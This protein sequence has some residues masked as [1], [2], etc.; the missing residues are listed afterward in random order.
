MPAYA[1][2]GDAMETIVVTGTRITASGFQAPTP[3]SMISAV[4][5]E[6]NAQPNIFTTITQLPSLMGSAGVQNNTYS[7]S[8]G[9]Q[10]L[11]SFSLRGLGTIRTLTLLDGQRVVGANVTGTPDVSL[12]PQILIERVDVVTGGASASWGS[13]AVG[14]V[15]NFVTN[16]HF[17]GVKAN[18]QGGISTY[19]DNAQHMIQLAVGKSFLGGRLHVAVAGE[20]DHEDGVPAGDLG[21]QAANGRTWYHAATFLNTGMNTKQS[22]Y[23]G[24]PQYIVSGHAQS[25]K[26][27]KY[28]LIN[29]GPLAG[30]AFDASGK[31]YPFVY[32]TGLGVAT[33]PSYQRGCFNGFCVGGD[34]S[35]GIGMGASITSSLHRL[36]AYTRVG[37]D[38]NSD[39]EIY[40]TVNMS[41]VNTSNQPYVGTS[42]SGLTI[43]CSNP[44]VPASVQQAC[45]ANNIT[46]FSFGTV[47]G[48]F[49]RDPIVMP[50]RK[51]VRLVVGADG[52]FD[53]AGVNWTYDAYLEHGTNVTDIHVHNI[54]LN[55]RY[56][57]AVNAT[58]LN[59]QA[60][61]ANATARAAGCVPLNVFG[62]D[63]VPDAVMDYI[64]PANGP[65]QHT[66]QTQDVAS[67]AING[68]PLSLWAGPVAVAFGGEYRREYYRV[69]A[70]PYGNGLTSTNTF[71]DQ[72]PA[73][74]V[75]NFDPAK[76][77]GS[78]WFAGN[79]HD[80]H[81]AF[82]VKEVF[83][84]TNV[85]V[86]DSKVFGSGNINLA[87]RWEDYSTAGVA[88]TWKIG[89]T[90][91]TPIEGVRFRGVISSDVRA[92]NLSELFAAPISS[93][94][95]N[96]TNPFNNSTLTV[97][98]NTVGNP[99]L[100]PEVAHNTEVGVVLS[101]PSWLPGFNASVDY[102]RI[103][104]TGVIN[105]TSDPVT[106]CYQGITS[107]C[108]DSSDYTVPGK[109]FWLPTAPGTVG[110]TNIQAFNMAW[111][112]TEGLDLEASY[113]FHLEDY[114]PGNF[115]VR[116]LATNVF[117][118]L[119]N[120]GTKGAVD[121][122]SAGNNSGSTP[123][124]KFLTVQSYDNE[125]FSFNIQE[126]WF[127]D[128]VVNRSYIQC[129]TNCPIST[130]NYRTVSDNF[131]AGAFYLDIGG[132]YNITDSVQ[133]YFKIDNLLDQDPA[134][135]PQDNTGQDVGTGLY[136]EIGRMYRIGIRVHL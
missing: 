77:N 43:Q 19:G 119:Q 5:I 94:Q 101:Q 59:G 124:W 42:Q 11:S 120:A 64:M 56:N 123:H 66:Y 113:Q 13:D 111:I 15:V 3:T 10:G 50:S 87:G 4:D 97:M 48:N 2:A 112:F 41:Q 121:T 79:Y 99:N 135:M 84:E 126:R 114:V 34:L 30:T 12:F 83:I 106:L 80:G 133:T 132:T 117:T 47:N 136:D 38:L 44:Y 29:A 57:N 18:V 54:V 105:N 103:R 39:N 98:T 72:Y 1:Q 67:F 46:N 92:P 89:G 122:Q 49:S 51:Q 28:G 31:P 27:A 134:A 75:L 104:V 131:M 86:F 36:N 6:K 37:Y 109:F 33:D 70:D 81:G 76:T 108:N 20:Y 91:D 53:L 7:T 107:Y 32:G 65:L 60:V 52:K 93:T 116:G 35:A 90:W 96:Y 74:P 63:A 73:D 115:T 69:K 21:E 130:G 71:T 110:Y 17:E 82:D 14:G 55:S 102:Y 22:N 128:G 88:W 85:P 125:K 24:G 8:S 95:P 127:S 40:A 26:Y 9:T 16:K 58:L 25:Y 68:Q 129:Q 23:N 61:C 100:K 62:G 78:N 45:A 118:Y